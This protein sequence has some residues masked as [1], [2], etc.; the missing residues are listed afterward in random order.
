MI[1]SQSV[2]S[3]CCRAAAASKLGRHEEAA[4]DA[5]KA[6][7][8]DPDFAKAYLRRAAAHSAMKDFEAAIRDY[9]KVTTDLGF[10][11]C[12]SSSIV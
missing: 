11:P 5:T 4:G 1:P 2:C 8:F 12:T 6:I 10:S 7:E 3:L 9:E